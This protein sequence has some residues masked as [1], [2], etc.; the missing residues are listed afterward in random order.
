MV[1]IN[2]ASGLLLLLVLTL[3][4]DIMMDIMD[5]VS[6]SSHGDEI[7]PFIVRMEHMR[8]YLRYVLHLSLLNG[9]MGII[10]GIIGVWGGLR[11]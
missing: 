3:G 9:C 8:D 4:V 6:A 2:S 10:L 5:A 1:L 11:R 7:A